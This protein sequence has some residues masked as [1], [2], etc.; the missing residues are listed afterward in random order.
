M[1]VEIKVNPFSF[2]S[3]T[4]ISI[5]IVCTAHFKCLALIVC[6]PLYKTTWIASKNVFSAFIIDENCYTEWESWEPPGP[7]VGKKEIS[8]VRKCSTPHPVSI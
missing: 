5:E 7:S 4:N 8:F 1:L 3:N 6:F 2:S